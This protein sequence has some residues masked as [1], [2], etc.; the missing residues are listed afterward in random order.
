[1]WPMAGITACRNDDGN[2]RE[3]RAQVAR[4]PSGDN[5]KEDQSA[6]ARKEQCQFGIKTHE[7]RRDNR[8]ARHRDPMLQTRNDR[9]APRQALLGHDHA[10]CLQLP[11]WKI[12]LSPFRN[13]SRRHSPPSHSNNAL[14]LV[15]NSIM[16]KGMS[17]SYEP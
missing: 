11:M 9:L 7:E 6:D 2:E 13:R 15:L 4:Y 16:S 3:A 14:K 8:C 17:A 12:A 1:V 10:G 5:D